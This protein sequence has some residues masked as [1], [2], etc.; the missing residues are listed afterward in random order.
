M[1]NTIKFGLVE[2]IG[3]DYIL[4]N[5]ARHNPGLLG[6]VGYRAINF[7]ASL[8]ATSHFVQNGQQDA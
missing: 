1:N 7:Y 8:L 4:T 3:E 2:R 6:S 5:C